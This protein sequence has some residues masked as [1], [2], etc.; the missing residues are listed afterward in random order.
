ML[1]TE[2]SSGGLKFDLNG[3]RLTRRGT[4]PAGQVKKKSKK[5]KKKKSKKP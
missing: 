2:Q 5:A 1:T 3:S 4:V